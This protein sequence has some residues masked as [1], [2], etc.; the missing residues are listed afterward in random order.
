MYDKFF[1]EGLGLLKNM[2]ELLHFLGKV[3]YL[4]TECIE[5]RGCIA[6]IAWNCE[7]CADLCKFHLIFSSN[8]TRKW[9]AI[10][11]MDANCSVWNLLQSVPGSQA[12]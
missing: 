10:Q 9:K 3:R 5:M 12:L 1:C 8:F 7:N 11:K 6:W 2:I 4:K